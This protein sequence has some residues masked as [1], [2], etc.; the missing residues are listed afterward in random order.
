MT[1]IT[2]RKSSQSQFSL[3]FKCFHPRFWGIYN[4][5]YKCEFGLREKKNCSTY[6]T[7]RYKIRYEELV[8]AN[9]TKIPNL[10]S[11]PKQSVT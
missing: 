4:K 10:N 11:K 9:E 1:K 3:D 5:S 7:I 2:D 6:R 8:M